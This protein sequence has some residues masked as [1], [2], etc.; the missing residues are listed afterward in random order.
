MQKYILIIGPN[1]SVPGGMLEIERQIVKTPMPSLPYKK[2]MIGTAS[3]RNKILVFFFSYIQI[4]ALCLLRKV[5]LAHINMSEGGSIIRTSILLKMFNYFRIRTIVHSHGSKLEKEYMEMSADRRKRF[6]RAMSKADRVIVLTEGWRKI[7]EEIVPAENIILLPNGTVVPDDKEKVYLRDGILH[8]L[9]LGEIGE[10]KGVYDLINAAKTLSE[11]GV[12]YILN[13]AGDGEQER[14]QEYIDKLG[15]SET[16]KVLGWAGPKQKEKL[17][18]ESDVLVLPSHYES[19]GISAIEA[20]AW[21]LPVVCGDSGFTKEIVVDGQTGYVA[22]T[23]DASDIADKII[24]LADVQ[25]LE[26]MGNNAEKL[27]R[28][29]YELTDIMRQL[30]KIYGELLRR[31]TA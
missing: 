9:F 22:K 14:C 29:K 24:Q 2:K 10:R 23:G 28:E 12:K 27:V 21:K 7:W 3:K 11:S 25:A 6:G 19:F 17:L 20:M 31:T 13:I 30:E 4:L 8:I 18:K 16:V 26:T 5:A 1:E 15:L